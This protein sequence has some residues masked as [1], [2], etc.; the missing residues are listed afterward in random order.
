[1]TIHNQKVARHITIESVY[2]TTDGE[3]VCAEQR[4]KRGKFQCFYVGSG[5]SA[6]TFWP[7]EL[8]LA[9]IDEVSS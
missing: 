1:V 3:F 2:E 5:R 9:V 6:G 7:S 4:I 8:K